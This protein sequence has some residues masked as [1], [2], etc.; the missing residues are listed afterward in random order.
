MVGIDGYFGVYVMRAPNPGQD[1]KGSDPAQAKP[2]SRRKTSLTGARA[3]I[4]RGKCVGAVVNTL[5]VLRHLG[6]ADIDQRAIDVARNLNM[7]PSTCF[8]IL[9]TLVVEGVVSFHPIRKLYRLRDCWAQCVQDDEDI[10]DLKPKAEQLASR[11]QLFISVWQ[12]SVNDRLAL[13]FTTE[14]SLP[15]EV[16]VP[17]GA[18]AP[19][20]IGSAGRMMAAVSRASEQQLRAHFGRLRWESPPSFERYAEDIVTAS[21]TGWAL[22][23]ENFARGFVT[24]SVPLKDV[25]RQVTYACS[26]TMPSHAWSE[27]RG[28][29]IAAD[30]IALNRLLGRRRR[31]AGFRQ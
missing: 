4:P 13:V 31:G 10:F 18:R 28:A 20:F 30:L 23:R 27:A 26:A 25:T 9:Q 2:R 11:H 8:N 16:R 15:F 5:E 1:E 22:D 24:I 19:L 14:T 29:S 12:R 3:M 21:Q 17:P 6:N 7:N